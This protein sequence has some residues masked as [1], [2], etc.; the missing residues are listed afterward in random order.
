MY[1]AS[2]SLTRYVGKGGEMFTAL[3]IAAV[4]LTNPV[5]GPITD[6]YSPIG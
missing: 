6:G 3:A 5:N 4:C 1:L 2:E